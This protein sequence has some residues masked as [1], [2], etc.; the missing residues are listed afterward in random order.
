MFFTSLA[1]LIYFYQ[2]YNSFNKN[3][4]IINIYSNNMSYNSYQY[5][6]IYLFLT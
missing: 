4:T 2:F 5:F 3:I 1:N 6:L